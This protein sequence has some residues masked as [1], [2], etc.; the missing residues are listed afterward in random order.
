[1][2]ARVMTDG[3]FMHQDVGFNKLYV[4]KI[5]SAMREIQP[6]GA[7]PR[8]LMTGTCIHMRILDKQPILCLCRNR[9]LGNE[10]WISIFSLTGSS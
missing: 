10:G 2:S 1:M 7:R 3:C 5:E 6:A 8:L 4:K 9:W